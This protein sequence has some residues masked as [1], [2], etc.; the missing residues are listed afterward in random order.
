MDKVENGRNFWKQ[1]VQ[2]FTYIFL[3]KLGT[4]SRLNN[5]MRTEKVDPIYVM[6]LDQSRSLK[7]FSCF[8][9]FKFEEI[10]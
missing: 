3:M 10:V 6:A 7:K 1:Y 2:L 9:I 4:V 8:K 5:K